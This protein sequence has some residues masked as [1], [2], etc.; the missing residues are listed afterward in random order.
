MDAGLDWSNCRD[1]CNGRPR[2]F[3]AR[4]PRRMLRNGLS[5]DERRVRHRSDRPRYLPVD[6]RN[7]A[8]VGVVVYVGYGR[9]VDRRIAGVDV[10]DVAAAHRIGR[11]VHFTRRERKPANS[12]AATG[13]GRKPEVVAANECNQS[14]RVDRLRAHRSGDPTPG[15]AHVRPAT[16]VGDRE[17][18]GR[19]IDPRPAPR[20]DPRPVT[21]LIRRPVRCHAIGHPHVPV[22]LRSAPAAVFVEIFV[23]DYIA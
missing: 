20:F 17:T 8:H 21:I 23:T 14:R 16:V 5:L 18:P 3:I 7:I 9:R 2:R 12:T 1:W 19:V 6:I 11:P 15:A 10:V 22:S 4:Y 13:G